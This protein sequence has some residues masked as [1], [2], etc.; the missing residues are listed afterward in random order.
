MNLVLLGGG[1]HAKACASVAGR[2]GWHVVG[3]IAPTRVSLEGCPW[4]GTDS[5]LDGEGTSAQCSFLV[6]VGQVSAES[7]RPRLFQLLQDR[8]LKIATLIA[9]SAVLA[10]SARI[11]HGSAVMER[12]VIGPAANIGEN[13]I[14]NTGAIV[15][16]DVQIGDHCHVSTGAVINGNCYVGSGTMLGSGAVVI[17]GVRICAGAVIGAGAVVAA[18]I[19]E[20]GKWVGVPARRI[21]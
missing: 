13:C 3:V 19:V 1:G 20:P 8:A 9:Q 12:A 2:A 7:I 4:L 14:L 18:D 21:S 6:S 17:Q 16:H 5:W 10:I 11:G 15:E